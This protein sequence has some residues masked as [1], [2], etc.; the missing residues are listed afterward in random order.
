MIKMNNIN[1]LNAVKKAKQES[2]SFELEKNILDELDVSKKNEEDI[3]PSETFKFANSSWNDPLIVGE[4]QSKNISDWNKKDF[5]NF[6]KHLYFKKFVSDMSVAPAYGYMYLNVIEEICLKNFPE[7][8]TKLLKAKY[9]QWYFNKHAL[10]DTV[11]FRSWNIKRM[12]AP[13][14]V[15]SFILDASGQSV[16]EKENNKVTRLPVNESILDLY[17]RGDPKDFLKSYGIIIPFAYL[18]F[19]K[20]FT[21]EDS[22][23]YISSAIRDMADISPSSADTHLIKVTE[24]YCPYNQK[25][26]K[27]A[28]ERLLLV[29]SEKTGLN[30]TGVKIFQ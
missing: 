29:L 25:F 3:F 7:S 22:A 12:V 23:D 6:V 1:I 4:F 10:K 18:F 14:V 11:R 5:L 30:F 13:K 21:W 27:I 15:A 16:S 8:N 19:S 2:T 9:I 26:S 20:K 24:Q 28:P 17:A